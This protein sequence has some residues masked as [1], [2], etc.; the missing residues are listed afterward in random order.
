[1]YIYT[2]LVQRPDYSF[3]VERSAL[4]CFKFISMAHYHL[5]RWTHGK[6]QQQPSL[7]MEMNKKLNK[8]V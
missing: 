3:C 2:S 6:Q 7:V 1:M 4:I 8:N 5:L